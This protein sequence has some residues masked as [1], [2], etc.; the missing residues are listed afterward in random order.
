MD[1]LKLE[2][3]YGLLS[4]VKEEEGGSDRLTEQIKA[5]RRQLAMDMGVIMPSV[6]ILDNMQLQPNEYKVRIKEVESGQ[7]EVYPDQYMVMDPHGGQIDLPGQHTIEPTF[8]LPATWV[9]AA[10]RD[11]AEV[12]G[13]TIVDPSSVISTHLTEIL[14]NQYCRRSKLRK[15][16]RAVEQFACRTAKTRRRYGAEPNQCFWYPARPTNFVVRAHFDPRSRHYS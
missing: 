2:L 1:D 13:Y 9:D 8:G 3:G 4:L 10:L 14:K 16:S 12:K 5:L 11:E 7:G 15:R 6:R